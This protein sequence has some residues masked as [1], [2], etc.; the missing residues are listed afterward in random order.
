VVQDG[1]VKLVNPQT[2]ELVGYSGDEIV[3][4]HFTDFIHPDDREMVGSYYQKRIAGEEIPSR[5]S[6]RLIRKDGMTRW[7][8]ISAVKILWDGI[9]ATLNFLID[10]TKRKRAEIALQESEE[11]YRILAEG[12]QVG[13]ITC[14]L[15]GTIIYLNP[16]ILDLVGSQSESDTKKINLLTFQP[17]IDAGL[18]G[19]L[20]KTL[21][22]GISTAFEFA[23]TS[24]WGKY[25]YYL[26]HISPLTREGKIS[27]A[28]IILD[29]ISTLKN[30]EEV[31]SESNQKLRLLTSLTRHDILNQITL[32]YLLQNLAICSEDLSKSQEYIGRAQQVTGQ[33]EKTIGFTREYENFAIVTGGWQNVSRI[34]ES[35]REEF[36]DMMISLENNIP[37]RLEIYADPIIRKV[38]YTLLENALRHGRKLTR[39]TFSFQEQDQGAIISCTDDGIGIPDNEKELIFEHGYGKNTGLG[40]FLARELLSITGLAIRETGV[41][42]EGAG[43][44]IIIPARKYRIA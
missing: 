8:E 24:V 34:I 31:V 11:R 10:I 6:F 28:Y 27:G 35:V 41:H 39:V 43:F 40:L 32:I 16:K 25:V 9:P 21:N 19:V 15:N 3:H 22:S 37:E 13:I 4:R 20:A 18:S 33:I 12:A 23:Y 30:S 42:T 44:E 38:F 1:A 5:Y 26:G 2:Q 17:L 14:D 36:P 7:V 29:D